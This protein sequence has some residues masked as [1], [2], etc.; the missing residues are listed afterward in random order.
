[1]L[2]VPRLQSTI[3]AVA[4]VSRTRTTILVSKRFESSTATEINKSG[5]SIVTKVTTATLLLTAGY[6]GAV[7]YALNNEAF[8]D[9][10]TTYVPGGEQVLDYIDEFQ[11]NKDLQ[12]YRQKARD[13]TK[14]ASEYA[15]TA[16]DYSIKA[17][18]ATVDAYEYASDTIA[19]LTGQSEGAVAPTPGAP[20]PVKKKGTESL[21]G[22]AKPAEGVEA[23][24]GKISLY[25]DD[26]SK[27]EPTK[28]TTQLIKVNKIQSNEPSI[29]QLSAVVSELADILNNAGMAKQGKEFVANAQNQLNH[30]NQQF[31]KLRNDQNQLLS[32]VVQLSK[33]GD[34]LT[35]EFD[36]YTAD[37]QGLVKKSAEETV[38]KVK[39]KE[40]E[41][42]EQFSKERAL[43]NE[44]FSSTLTTQ[45]TQQQQAQQAELKEALVAQATQL[46]RQFVNDVKHRVEQ[47]RA[48]RLAK[49]DQITSRY[50]AL[51]QHAVSNAEHIDRSR[52]THKGHIA[53]RTL[54]DKLTAP[55]KQPF[56]AELE[57]VRRNT[58]NLEIIQAALDT[59]PRELAQEGVDTIVDL[60]DRFQTVAAEVRNV[61]LV[62]QDGGLPSHV[63]S[64]VFGKLMFKKYG[65]VEG[66]DAEARLA[67]AEYYL[68][69]EDLENAARE[70]NQLEGWPKKLATDW[71]KAARRHLEVK[72]ALEIAETQILLSSLE[73]A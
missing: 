71:I 28:V 18:D 1:M 6:S 39:A 32:T 7:Y 19:K 10:F 70:L 8:H 51:E 9:T 31:D 46:Q 40:A 4:P 73:E 2:R 27:G 15:N 72:Q 22:S 49:L 29:I 53:V 63:V 59:I 17:K 13:L 35:S 58:A 33:R 50:Q 64:K 30:L 5:N 37:A 25:T 56:E 57:A 55:H 38:E 60:A 11:N 44:T 20:A 36:K 24:P 3:R 67:R 65:L 12:E 69:E 68:H 42:K 66:D 34:Q 16:K 45:L 54:R 14:Q 62:P 47:E 52:Q 26:E 41:L 48:G 43:L 23:K 61:A 21:F